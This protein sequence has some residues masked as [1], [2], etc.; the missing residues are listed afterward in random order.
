MVSLGADGALAV[1]EE[2]VWHG[3]PPKIKPVN[4]VGCGDSMVA[5]FAVGMARGLSTE[6][7]LKYAV[8]VSAAN[9]LTMKTGHYELKD[10]DEI[11]SKVTV[12]KIS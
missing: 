10:R 6:E 9:A 5:A 8:A 7:T 12:K 1:T 3:Q 4:T 2:G 11:L